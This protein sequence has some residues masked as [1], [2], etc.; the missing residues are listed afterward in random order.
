LDRLRARRRTEVPGLHVI[1]STQFTLGQEIPA[2]SQQDSVG[3]K[4]H[5]TPRPSEPPWRRPPEDILRRI[6]FWKMARAA[7]ASRNARDT[8]RHQRPSSALLQRKWMSAFSGPRRA[9]MLCVGTNARAVISL[10]NQ[11]ARSCSQHH[12]RP[13]QSHRAVGL[14]TIWISRVICSLYP[15]KCGPPTFNATTSRM[16]DKAKRKLWKLKRDRTHYL[17]NAVNALQI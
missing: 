6:Q 13:T 7:A 2:N 15:L 8:P 12:Q 16:G 14:P 9:E 5:A 11:M 17:L 1:S 10:L 3:L 4:A